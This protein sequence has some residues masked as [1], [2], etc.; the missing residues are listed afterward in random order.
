MRK[1]L[2]AIILIL[3]LLSAC[4]NQTENKKEDFLDFNQSSKSLKEKERNWNF[5][6]DKIDSG[7][8]KENQDTI[9][10]GKKS[11]SP[12][13]DY[14]KQTVTL[15]NGK[16]YYE[17]IHT[18]SLIVKGEKIKVF[19]TKVYSG[20]ND[21]LDKIFYI[22]NNR[23]EANDTISFFEFFDLKNGDWTFI[24][25]APYA[26]GESQYMKELNDDAYF[27]EIMNNLTY[28][29]YNINLKTFYAQL[30]GEKLIEESRNIKVVLSGGDMTTAYLHL[31]LVRNDTIVFQTGLFAGNKEGFQNQYLG[32][33]EISKK[34]TLIDF[35][36]AF[37][38]INK[39]KI[40]VFNKSSIQ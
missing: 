33:T 30:E 12:L 4:V 23:Y 25:H 14:K 26:M 37:K 8:I 15:D 11:H 5:I 35:L 3:F 7:S 22:N 39:E 24:L 32:W 18:K 36:K 28:G 9:I 10:D 6:Q 13:D 27:D 1:I 29:F 2:T 20:I 19:E 31:Y 38:P 21:G 16:K 40:S 17:R 34:N